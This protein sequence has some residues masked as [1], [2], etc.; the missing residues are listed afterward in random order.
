MTLVCL[1]LVVS[2]EK[3]KLY[4]PSMLFLKII[5]REYTSKKIFH[6]SKKEAN[7]GK[8]LSTMQWIE[9][10]LSL[11]V[12]HNL[13]IYVSIVYAV[14]I[15]NLVMEKMYHLHFHD[16]MQQKT[17]IP[18]YGECFY[19]E[20]SKEF[21]WWLSPSISLSHYVVLVRNLDCNRNNTT[22]SEW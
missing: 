4:W 9:S 11:A 13:N 16:V 14:I 2:F 10:N 6:N 5:N 15:G 18:I 19:T 3:L 1:C 22:E 20:Q 7:E 17:L 21:V 8:Y 12:L